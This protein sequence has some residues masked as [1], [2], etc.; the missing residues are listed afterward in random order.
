MCVGAGVQATINSTET[1]LV[2]VFGI[3]LG[4]MTA[5]I[6]TGGVSGGK[7]EKDLCMH[8]FFSSQNYRFYKKIGHVN[9]AVSI[10]L[11]VAGELSWYSLPG[12]LFSQFLG[13]LV[14]ALMA[15]G[16]L[17]RNYFK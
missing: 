5:I 7:L 8:L 3:I 2:P 12:Y 4:I 1:L 15:W 14:G 6:I 11:A 17:L 10:S 16:L 9:P 13:A